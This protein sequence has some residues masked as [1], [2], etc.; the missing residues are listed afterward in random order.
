MSVMMVRQKVK[1]GCVDAAEAAAR[2]LFAPLDR[3]R[4]ILV[5]QPVLSAH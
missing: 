4:P 1:E 2:D 5:P 3:V